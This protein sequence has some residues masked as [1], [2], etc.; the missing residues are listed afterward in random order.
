MVSLF[1]FITDFATLKIQIKKREPLTRYV[2][3]LID[4]RSI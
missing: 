1:S 3:I 2:L 4:D